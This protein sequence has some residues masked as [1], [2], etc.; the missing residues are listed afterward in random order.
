[1]SYSRDN[2]PPSPWLKSEKKLDTSTEASFVEYLRWM[3]SPDTDY[4]NETKVQILQIAAQKSKGYK[5]RLAELTKRTQL[6]AG[7]DN[8]FE[9]E[10]SWRI[11]V[12][13]HKGPENILLP[14]FDALG[15]PY[16]PSSTLRGVARAQGIKS[17]I[18]NKGLT[19]KEAER[20]IARYFGNL[21]AEEINRS[22]KVIFLDA[23]PLPTQAEVIAVDI[24]NNIW[25]W[26]GN[27]PDYNPNPNAFLSLKC[28]KFLI[29]LRQ[30]DRCSQQDFNQ[31][32]TWL[33]EGLQEGIGSQVNSGYGELI[34][35]NEENQETETKIVLAVPFTLTGQ[36]I[37]GCQKY[38]NVYQPFQKDR[39]GN[40]RTD[41]KGNLK[42]DANPEYE[43]RPI[44]FKSMLRYWFRVLLL[45]YLPP[46]VVQEWEAKLFG[47]IQPQKQGWLKVKL[48]NVQ[49]TRS[50]FQQKDARCLQQ[51]GVLELTY[52]AV[53][54]DSEKENFVN[55]FHN[56]TWLMFHLGGVGQGARR[57][58]YSRMNRPRQPWYRGTKLEANLKD[59]FWNIPEK[60]QDFQRKFQQRL[61]DFYKAFTAMSN[62][63]INLRSPLT[64]GQVSKQSW[65][66]VADNNCRILV[67]S[68]Q[69]EFGKP[70]ALAV[71]H[72]DQLK[73]NGNYDSYLCGKTGDR[74]PIWIAD[75]G[76][77][78]V[79]TVFGAIADPRQKYLNLLEN[80]V[81]LFPLS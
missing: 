23:Y 61:N 8:T 69:E 73:R 45:G 26:K 80:A 57:P 13:G 18:K 29:G 22:G 43:V 41:K 67:S 76:E 60:A 7:E 37:H 51:K 58:L 15:F 10:C 33:I 31:V 64:I 68:G 39:Q 11:R 38:P 28:P 34:V 79:I 21:E 35:S 17:L 47:H 25:N 4:T 53:M 62:Q 56:L 54:P 12:G 74:S 50:S 44:A 5:N 40:L 36:L 16:I 71:L 81:Q 75:L 49:N 72:Q 9:A 77:Y 3:R 30:M 42:S 52:S 19:R 6:I 70:Y 46:I 55:L 1:M 63:T 78:Q 24:A 48:S 32:R 65:Q 20:E 27:L 59:D 66:E 14:A 2:Q